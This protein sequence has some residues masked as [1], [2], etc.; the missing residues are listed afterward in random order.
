MNKKE[1]EIFLKE[2]RENLPFIYNYCEIIEIKKMKSNLKFIANDS[3]NTAEMHLSTFF[4][5][6]SKIIKPLKV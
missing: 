4:K 3:Y 2:N 1:L 5:P 6:I